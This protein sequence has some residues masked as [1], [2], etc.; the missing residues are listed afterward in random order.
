MPAQV[1]RVLASASGFV[2]Y[3]LR[4][5]LTIAL[6]VW[7]GSRASEIV[8]LRW[9]D[10]VSETG[11]VRPYLGQVRP[12]R[13]PGLLEPQWRPYLYHQRCTENLDGR[14]FRPRRSGPRRP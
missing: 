8:N 13:L 2:R 14:R 4:S 3:G 10:L 11:K 5:E 12:A 9:S 7:L 6:S 1:D